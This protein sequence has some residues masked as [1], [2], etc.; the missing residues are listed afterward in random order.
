[1]QQLSTS[2]AIWDYNVDSHFTAYSGTWRYLSDLGLARSSKSRATGAP[3]AYPTSYG[4][5]MWALVDFSCTLNRSTVPTTDDNV[6]FVNWSA[7][8]GGY[9][10]NAISGSDNVVI[11]TQAGYNWLKMGPGEWTFDT[12]VGHTS[13]ASAS[14]LD[15]ELESVLYS[16]T[17]FGTK[18]V[19]GGC[20]SNVYGLGTV[21]ATAAGVTSRMIMSYYIPPGSYGWTN[22][23]HTFGTDNSATPGDTQLIRFSESGLGPDPG[24]T[25]I[26]IAICPYHT[27]TSWYRCQEF[28]V[29]AGSMREVSVTALVY[30][31]STLDVG[32]YGRDDFVITYPR[33]TVTPIAW[34]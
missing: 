9:Q 1:M 14:E 11:D 3:D 31:T 34:G 8:T 10:V 22:M 32:F 20:V 27:G 21:A 2:R 12:P 18:T 26:S 24:D 30:V 13:T 17:S 33:I 5:P 4:G 15:S 23:I 19:L 16:G 28:E 7:V 25:A 29:P 6:T